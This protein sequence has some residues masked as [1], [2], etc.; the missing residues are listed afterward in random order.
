MTSPN[1]QGKLARWSLRLQEF[2][3]FTIEYRKGSKHI[4]LL[5]QC[6]ET[7]VSMKMTSQT[8]MT[9]LQAPSCLP[10]PFLMKS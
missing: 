7:L 1:L 10:V 4:W 8:M 2:M 6:L 3:P 9:L 5:M